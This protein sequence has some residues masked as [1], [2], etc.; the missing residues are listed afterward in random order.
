MTLSIKKVYQN[1]LVFKDK[2]VTKL[3][4]P[5]FSNINIKG[6]GFFYTKDACSLRLYNLEPDMI[7]VIPSFLGGGY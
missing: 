7:S 5:K 1:N 4:V 3:E 2:E 6:I